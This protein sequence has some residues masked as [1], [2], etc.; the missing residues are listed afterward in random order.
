LDDLDVRPHTNTAINIRSRSALRRGCELRITWLFYYPTC[1]GESHKP[2]STWR[3][4]LQASLSRL[5]RQV[6]AC[7]KYSSIQTKREG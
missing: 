1:M 7:L 4:S 3:H 2:A 5:G 6:N